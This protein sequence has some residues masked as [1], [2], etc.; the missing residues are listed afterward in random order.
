MKKAMK[1]AIMGAVKIAAFVI[2]VVILAAVI[3]KLMAIANISV[4]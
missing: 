2:A 4:F 1:R 3:I